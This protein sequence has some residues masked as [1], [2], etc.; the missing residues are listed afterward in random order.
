M[1]FSTRNFDPLTPL[2]PK[3]PNFATQFFYCFFAWNTLLPSSHMHMCYKFFT[4]L[5]YCVLLAKKHRL[6]PKLEGAGL[7][8]IPKKIWDPLQPL[9][10]ATSNLVHNLG[11]GQAYQKTTIWTKIG[12]NLGQGSIRKN[13]GPSSLFLQPLKLATSNLV[14]NLGLGL[15]YQKKQRLGPKLAGV[16]GRGASR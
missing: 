10:L 2:A 1:T 14:C 8:D 5:G 6:G 3:F 7:G 16:W 11:L 12:G 15:A 4:P 13:V 9:K